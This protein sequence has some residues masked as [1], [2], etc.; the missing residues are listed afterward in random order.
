MPRAM[1]ALP[2]AAADPTTLPANPSDTGFGG[3]F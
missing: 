2:A 1:P 3:P